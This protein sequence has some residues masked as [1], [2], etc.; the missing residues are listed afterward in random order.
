MMSDSSPDVGYR[1]TVGYTLRRI[2]LSLKNEY[3]TEHRQIERACSH[4]GNEILPYV[5]YKT[6]RHCVVYEQIPIIS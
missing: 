1:C 4:I 5:H 6:Q 3:L 2:T